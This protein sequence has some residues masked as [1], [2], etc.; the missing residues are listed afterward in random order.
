MPDDSILYSRRLP[1]GPAV[2]VRRTSEKGT[3]P[4]IAV[5]EVDRRAGTPREFDGGFPPP[6]M[7]VEGES[8]TDVLAALGPPA[9]DDRMVAGLM[10]EK[11][12][13]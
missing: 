7:I 6:L 12:L 2:R 4:V 8:E 11:G 9:R 1:H 5:L 10:R 3:Q 13:R